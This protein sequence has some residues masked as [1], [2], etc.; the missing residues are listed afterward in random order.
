MMATGSVSAREVGVASGELGTKGFAGGE[1]IW[2]NVTI[3]GASAQFGATASRK[4]SS[5]Q[6]MSDGEQSFITPTSS[7][8]DGR[9]YSGTTVTPSA[10]M[11]ISIATQRILLCAMSAQRSPLFT[12]NWRRNARA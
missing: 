11:A 3:G 7:P 1:K 2:S 8:A 6:Q 10:R 4:E 5:P 9:A 12:F